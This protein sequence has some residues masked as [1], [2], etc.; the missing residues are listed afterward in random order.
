MNNWLIFILVVIIGSYLLEIAIS[1]LNLKALDP[2]LPPEFTD[3]FDA[4]EY[5]KSQQYTRAKTQLALVSGSLSTFAT[6]VFLLLG[7][8]N[9]VDKLAI[10]LEL[11]SIFTGL[12]FA[13]TLSLLGFLLTVPFSVYSTFVI[14][15][16]FGFNNTTPATYILDIL[17]SAML[18]VVLGGPL[19]ALILWFFETAGS[20]AW[21]YCWIGVVLFSIAVQFLAPV[22]IL[23]LFNQFSPLEDGELKEAISTY[24]KGERFRIQGIFTMDGSK[25][26]SKVNAFFTGFGRFRKIVF[27][28]TLLDKLNTVEILA[29]LAHEMG[30]F[31]K[32][33]II[34]MLFLSV[35]QTGLMFFFLS[36]I[37]NNQ[38]LFDAFRMENVS[39]YAS[40]V[41]FGYLFAP[42]NMLLSILF[43]FI[44]RK[45]EYEA[46]RYAVVSSNNQSA[47]ISGLKKLSQANLV[48]L[49]PHPAAVFLEYTHPPVL[50]RIEAIRNLS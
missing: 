25:R 22:I 37:L 11:N 40:L 33:H 9:L 17:K 7:G 1:L 44:S 48:N 16:R 28:D 39:V 23:P 45:H 6:L 29:V 32:R 4:D 3:V 2:K 18:L 5:A 14:E 36:L 50:E 43:N 24:A 46:D 13:A 12:I 27:Y 15:E 47:L 8:F 34:K 41:F 42:V 21:I 26:S 19:L 49:T 35:A 20:V 10:S 38:G 30:H 31:K